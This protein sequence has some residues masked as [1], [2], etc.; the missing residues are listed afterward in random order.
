MFGTEEA[1][2]AALVLLKLRR[3]YSNPPKQER[4]LDPLF[5]AY[6]KG[7]LGNVKVSR[8]EPIRFHGSTHPSRIDFRVGGSNPTFVELAVRPSLGI[9]ELMG[10]QNL[11][12]LKK[13]SKIR[14]AIARR[15]MLILLDLKGKPLEKG[16]LKPSYDPLH[17]GPGRRERHPVT[18]IYVHEEL[19]YSFTWSPYKK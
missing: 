15:R 18:V 12:E 8:Q 13:L 16:K 17:V 5:Y 3:D 6:L 2:S 4:T 1:I 7:H 10:P 14:P 9:Q 11:K 19:Q